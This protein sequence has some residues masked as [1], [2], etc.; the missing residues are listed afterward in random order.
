MC[1]HVGYRGDVRGA[2]CS[3]VGYRGDVRGAVCSHVGYRGDVRDKGVSK[4]EVMLTN[5][6]PK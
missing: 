1:S 4:Q 5:S 3:H 2:V 6:T